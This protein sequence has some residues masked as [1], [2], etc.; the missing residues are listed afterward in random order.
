MEALGN[1]ESQEIIDIN[2]QT[3]VF[4][5]LMK[6]VLHL[7]VSFKKQAA[8]A[9]PESWRNL[10]QPYHQGGILASGRFL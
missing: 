8:K 5:S 4:Q 9:N 6:Q 7:R 2:A 1:R 3:E 10:E